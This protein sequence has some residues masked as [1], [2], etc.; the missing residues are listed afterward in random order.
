M[1][2]VILDRDGVINEDSDHY[3]RS[4]EQWHPVAGSIEAI[5]RLSRAGYRIA[6]AT[7]QSGLGRGYFSLA[8]LEAI[9]AR[10]EAQVTR[11]GGQLSCICFCPH[12]PADLCDCRK[13]RP[14]LVHQIEKKLGCPAAGAWLV[15]DSLCDM[16]LALRCGCKPALVRTGKGERTLASGDLDR[17]A[18][19][20][21][22]NLSHFTRCLLNPTQ[23]QP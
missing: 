2:L 15:G 13:P 23:E 1:T 22:D 18:V 20:V 6:V 7:N 17:G 3:I 4:P 14:G 9:H 11:A 5:A 10:L 8:T 21:F 12:T 19:S 16:Q